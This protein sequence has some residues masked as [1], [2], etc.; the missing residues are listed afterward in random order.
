MANLQLI[1]EIAEQRNIA[2][3]TIATELGI[4]PQALSKLIRNNS[5]KIETL[6]KIA[7]ILKVSVATFFNKEEND[8]ASSQSALG[9]HNTQVAGN[10]NR[11]NADSAM[12]DKALD[13]IAEM[14]KLLA[15]SIRNN[16]EQADR[17]LAIIEKTN[18]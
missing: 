7:H 13:E 14:R 15:E 9:G 8:E 17:F 16:K 12:L 6:E 18:K 10:G 11:V 1:K 5:T 3:A 4:T 2:L